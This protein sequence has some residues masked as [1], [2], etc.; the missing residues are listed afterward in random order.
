MAFREN[1]VSLRKNVCKNAKEFAQ[2]AGISYTTYVS[3]EKGVWP[4]EENLVKIAA[5]LNVTIDQLLGHEVDIAKHEANLA[6]RAGLAVQED[7]GLYSVSVP[8]KT[9][10]RID[11]F[12]QLIIDNCDLAPLPAAEFANAVKLARLNVLAEHTG[13]FILFLC[14][15]IDK[16]HKHPPASE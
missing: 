16:Y 13:R 15:T 5:T 1:L 6:R 7:N 9:Y 14:N 10:D 12:Y 4:S 2:L 3:Y 11:G 8:P